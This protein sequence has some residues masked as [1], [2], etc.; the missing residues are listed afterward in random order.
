MNSSKNDNT[1][2]SPN[3]IIINFILNN[4]FGVVSQTNDDAREFEF[5]YKIYQNKTRDYYAYAQLNIKIRYDR[6]YTSL[7]F[8]AGDEAYL[9]LHENYRIPDIK[10]KKFTR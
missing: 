8:N 1:G 2:R 5:K 6:I 10:G 9:N 4:F 3:E 7:F